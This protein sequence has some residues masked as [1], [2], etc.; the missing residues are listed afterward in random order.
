MERKVAATYHHK[1]GRIKALRFSPLYRNTKRKFQK[2]R[3][4]F[5]S[6]Y[7]AKCT[8]N[9]LAL[10]SLP[11]PLKCKINLPG[12]EFTKNSFFQFN[13]QTFAV[14]LRPDTSLGASV[15]T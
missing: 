5:K 15:M 9:G 2:A 7:F 6:K 14:Y 1:N 13:H 10:R 11:S 3:S 8:K 12:A 4:F